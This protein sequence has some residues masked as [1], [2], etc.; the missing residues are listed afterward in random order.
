MAF[1]NTPG[2]VPGPRVFFPF[3]E[4]PPY[5]HG[6]SV[7][8]P[9][10][11]RG[12]SVAGPLAALGAARSGLRAPRWPACFARPGITRRLPFAFG[13]AVK[14]P[15]PSL[16]GCPG[17]PERASSPAPGSLANLPDPGAAERQH[18]Q[19]GASGP[20]LALRHLGASTARAAAGE[21]AAATPPVFPS[22]PPRAFPAAPAAEAVR[23]AWQ[24]CPPL[25]S[26][27]N[28]TRGTI[29]T[30]LDHQALRPFLRGSQIRVCTT[31]P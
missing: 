4:I 10:A 13:A 28:S 27:P 30:A 29:Q 31:L 2:N 5:A 25:T 12:G 24:H 16:A 8:K 3:L 18:G 6:I 19:P 20:L 14:V 26:V 15:P 21:R 22:R 7:S 17:R 23:W 9:Q 1:L 11:R